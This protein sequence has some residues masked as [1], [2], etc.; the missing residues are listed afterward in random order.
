MTQDQENVMG[1]YMNM[2]A[3]YYGA[4]GFGLMG[5][6]ATAGQGM[7]AGTAVGGGAT[8]ALGFV[9]AIKG[10]SELNKLDKNGIPKFRLNQDML[11]SIGEADAMR[12]T[13]FTAAEMAAIKNRLTTSQATGF[14]KAADVSPNLVNVIQAGINYT[15]NQ[16]QLDIASK[17][18]SLRRENI[19]YSDSLRKYKQDVTN[20]NTSQ[21]IKNYY[22]KQEAY[23]KAAQVGMNN[24]IEGGT[25]LADQ[26]Q[27]S[28]SPG[29]KDAAD[30][31][32]RVRRRR[33]KNI[34]G[35][36]D[37]GIMNNND[38]GLGLGYE[39]DPIT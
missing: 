24:V 4:G 35:A 18:A 36:M 7:S 15:N 8:M 38:F 19:R 17:D 37:S 28:M 25:I 5:G 27:S 31:S 30:P 20:M 29:Q 11:N 23:G 6:S 32:Q 39:L 14:Q 10:F 34:S 13:G 26:A 22:M 1:Q 3:K 16:V 9:Q 2:I 33:R 12:G 21:A